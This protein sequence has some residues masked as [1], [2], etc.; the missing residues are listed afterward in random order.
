MIIAVF[1]AVMP[2]TCSYLQWGPR[3]ESLFPC[4]PLLDN[5]RDLVIDQMNIDNGNRH[6]TFI[7][8]LYYPH[9]ILKTVV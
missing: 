5:T 4:R 7:Y 1:P 2:D 3:A 8:C 6:V 9:N